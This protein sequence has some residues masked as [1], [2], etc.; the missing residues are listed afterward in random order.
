[1]KIIGT[2]DTRNDADIL[3]GVLD[4][5]KGE[6]DA[7]YV[8]DDGSWDSTPSILA[9]HPVVTKRWNRYDFSEQDRKKH[10]Q[11][12]RGFLLDAV[13]LDYPYGTEDIWIV[14]VESDRF[15]INQ[16]PREI[17]DRAIK[18]GHDSRCGVHL[19]FTRHRCEGWKEIDTFPKW[20]VRKIM[21]WYRL[22][23][24]LTSV[25]FKVTDDLVF[26][27]P[28][29]WPVGWKLSDY[30]EDITKEM[31]FFAHYGKRSPKYLYL[32]I[33][34][35]NRPLSIKYNWDVSSIASIESTASEWFLPVCVLPWE[36]FD[37]MDIETLNMTN[38]YVNN[39]HKAYFLKQEKEWFGLQTIND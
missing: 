11:H 7:L 33:M 8:Y 20:D 13:K 1:M 23:E 32:S 2:L 34:T 39:P 26:S 37:N 28:R 9:N 3:P 17:I 24:V 35:A 38:P 12:R 4:Q 22:A 18:A 15:F 10:I 21:K 16:F 6:L 36:G 25:A 19:D 31:A 5:L 29:P 14:R 27:R 30:S